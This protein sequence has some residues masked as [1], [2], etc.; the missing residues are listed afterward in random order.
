MTQ[1][2]SLC[3][4]QGLVGFLLTPSICSWAVGG[5]Q[6]R[7]QRPKAHFAGARAVLCTGSRLVVLEADGALWADE[8]KGSMLGPG[9]KIGG[10]Q[11]ASQ[12]QFTLWGN[13]RLLTMATNG[14]VL[15][16]DM[17]SETVGAGYPLPGSAV[18]IE[19]P[20]LYPNGRLLYVHVKSKFGHK[21]RG[22]HRWARVIDYWGLRYLA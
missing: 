3:A 14:D 5:A 1:N 7:Y 6:L 4:L 20:L 21:M 13:G 19:G 9:Y 16:Y 15:A 17:K 12:A 11:P 10:P 22:K 2:V 18:P 8:L